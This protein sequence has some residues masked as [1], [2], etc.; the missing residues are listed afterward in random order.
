MSNVLVVVLRIIEF[1][2]L[3][4]FL[5]FTHELGHFIIAR[6]SK[7]E[8]EEFGFG[9]PPKICR[10][11]RLWG[12]DF[13]LNAI[14]FGGF[15]R[16]KGEMDPT[17]PGGMGAAKP[18]ARLGVLLGGPLMNILTGVIIFSIIFSQVGVSNQKIVQIMGVTEN[19]PALIAGL[20]VG[21]IVKSINGEPI[22][23]MTKLSSMVYANLGKEM[24]MVVLRNN[25]EITL[26]VTPRTEPPEGEGPLGITMGNPVKDVNWIEAVPYG[27]VMA[28]DQAKALLEL[29]GQLIAGSI[30]PEQARLVGPVGMFNI[31]SQTRDLDQEEQAAGSS[32]PAGLNSLYLLAVL[33]VALG[34]TNLLPIPALDG[35]RVLF[36]LPELFF[37]KRIPP[38]YE[39]LV[40]L[41]GFSLLIVLMVYITAQDIFNPIALP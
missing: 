6:L 20:Q 8:V 13:T 33:A 24:Q 41:I 32:Q 30:S 23:N 12:T 15:V 35:G 27:F 26:S 34:L 37:K 31:F 29:P 28:Y 18:I 25:E 5:L 10:L 2:I 40:N 4:G 39:N 36:L 1:V 21:D 11:F 16:P 38:K 14:P 19:S 17:I 22:N 9:F 7:I 3:F